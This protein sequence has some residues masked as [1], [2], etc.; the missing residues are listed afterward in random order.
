MRVHFSGRAFDYQTL[1]ALAYTTFGGAEP[2]EV[3]ATVER[4]DDGDT[5]AWYDEWRRTAARV[6]RTAEEAR[7]AGHD[8]TARFAFLR[9][10]TYYRTAE[11][12]LPTDDP[13]RRPTYERSRATFRSGTALLDVPPERVAIPYEGTTLPG[14]VFASG[15]TGPRPTVVCLGGFDSLCEEL[16][17]LCG[18]PEAL[19]RGYDVV[20]FE[21]P[22]QGAPLR[23]E[24]LT[25]RPDWE[26]V[27][28]PV[29]DALEGREHVDESRM[30][31]VGVSFGGYYAPRAAAFDD[32]IAA[33]VAFD[34]MHDL[35][36]ASAVETPRLARALLY[37]P[38]RLVNALAAVGGRFSVEAR[39]LLSNSRWVFGVDSAAE[40]QRTL[41]EYSLT[42]VTHRIDCPTLVLAGEDDHFVPL[43]LAEEFVEDLT[44]PATL[45]VF[46]AEEGAGEHCQVG[47]LRLATGVVYDWLD[48][49]LS[50]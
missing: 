13:R 37:A 44:A 30:A 36:R 39:W 4:I 24:G 5:E 14:Y 31:L 1:R 6:E 25:A 34:H 32:R 17:F 16:Y 27:V 47:N 28:G 9:A 18:V 41:R 50:T 48:E 15:G 11:F 20:L 46:T 21:G 43:E 42:P 2:G 29:L 3:L 35:W 7:E 8:R 10:H 26:H 12:F 23:E 40:L 38:D 22:G 33:C 45:R 49:T 19:A